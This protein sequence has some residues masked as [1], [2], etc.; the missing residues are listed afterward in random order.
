M[1]ILRQ[2]A[3]DLDIDALIY[4]KERKFKINDLTVLIMIHEKIDIN[5]GVF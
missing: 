4:E 2:K 5:K 1:D 3:R